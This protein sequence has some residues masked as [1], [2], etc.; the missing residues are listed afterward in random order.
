MKSDDVNLSIR[1]SGQG[2]DAASAGDGAALAGGAAPLAS[3][4]TPPTPPV[5]DG[6]AATEGF[7]AINRAKLVAFFRAGVKDKQMFGYELEHIVLRKDTEGPVSYDE[8]GGIREVL[9]RMAPRYERRISHDD[10]L[11][12]LVRG[13]EV[14]SLEPAAQIEVSAGP[15]SKVSDAEQSYLSFRESL[16][17]VLEELGL[18]TP[19]VGYNPSVKASELRLIP[20]FRYDSMDRFLSAEAY[21]GVTM[22]RGSASLQVSI[23]YHSEQDAL[24][25]FRIAEAIAPILAL[26]CDNSPLYEG[27]VRTSQM[28]RMG[29]WDAMNQDRVGVVPGSLDPDFS[30]ERYADYILSRGAILVPDGDEWRYVGNQT[31][32]EV[33]ADREMTDFEVE[34]ALSMVWPDARLK[35]FVEIRPADAMPFDFSLAYVTLI[36]S[37]FYGPANLEVLDALLRGVTEDDVRA[38]K[39]DLFRRGYAAR[40]YGRS[41][42][43]WVDLLMNLAVG[44]AGP[45]EAFY[46]EPLQSMT[47][48]RFTLAD[49]YQD[50]GKREPGYDEKIQA[51][52]E[53]SGAPRVGIFPRYDFELTGISLS[54]GYT[55]GVLAAGGLPVVL[56]LTDNPRMLE[57]IV[58]VCDAFIIPGGQDIDPNFYGQKRNL[59]LHRVT[60]QRDEMELALIPRILQARKPIL[61]IC[62]GMQALAVANGGTLFHDIHLT[63]P[64]SAIGHVQGRPFDAPRHEVEVVPGTRL[65][66]ITGRRRFGVNTIHHQSV[67]DPG[68]NMVVSARA[69][70]GVVEAIEMTGDT[71]VVGVQWHPELLWR[72]EDSSHSL[73]RAL[74]HAAVSK[75]AAD[76][77]NS[78][79]L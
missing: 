32:Y 61:G 41:M 55:T 72:T 37:L 42:E 33:Y 29:V 58:E 8:P 20:K 71:F 50:P 79:G 69:D 39:H 60:R 26:M 2:A 30:F 5:A 70:D 56:P 67:K 57:K 66:Q 12:G 54:E 3:A 21:A 13:N 78:A 40:V 15:F 9:E 74:V 52:L 65:A 46:L 64:E 43:F 44:A 53:R 24:C 17:P 1:P 73:F 6:G 7:A 18:F 11:M 36:K 77:L 51:V 27:E 48:N 25:K 19:M 59:R 4:A 31:F 75:G 16:D 23:D 10:D 68:A 28:V 62:R 38:A 35:N 14:V 34:H 49:A 63:H 22:M 47:R 45:D 76:S